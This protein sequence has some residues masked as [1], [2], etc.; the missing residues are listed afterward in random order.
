[1]LDELTAWGHSCGLTFNPQKTVV[2]L[3]SRKRALPRKQLCIDGTP[4]P[5]SKTVVYLGVTLDS[6][7]S[8]GPH[9]LSLIHI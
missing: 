8:F 6:R 9:I 3:F 1:M 7:L 2:V 5:Y 4:V